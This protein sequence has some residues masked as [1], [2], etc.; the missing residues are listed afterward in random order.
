MVSAII[1][2]GGSSSRMNGINKQLVELDGVPV[3]VLSALKFNSAADV[4][5]VVI[6]SPDGC[7]EEYSRLARI[8]GVTKLKAVTAG[9]ATRFLS[10]KNAL[11]KVSDEA[12]Y[13]AIHDGARPLIQTE[14]IERVI[15]D[16]VKYG[17]SIAATPASDTVKISADGFVKSTPPRETLWYA[18]TPQIFSKK[19]YIDCVN[20][21]G[22]KADSVTDDSSILE[23]CGERV[24]ITE[25]TTNNMKMTRP[26]DITAA[27]AIY[28]SRGG[29]NS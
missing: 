16:A 20:N 29:N 6:V 18:Q 23:M 27:Q 2:A 21:L 25:I 12:D 19:L 11:C 26:D 17:A 15:A 24:F 28:H 10:V 5:E 3:F 14:D 1:L 9:G 22:D 13:I 4:D 7:E 8:Y